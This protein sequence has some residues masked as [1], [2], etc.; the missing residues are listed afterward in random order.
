MLKSLIL[1]NK[2][3]AVELI[4]GALLASSVVYGI[5]VSKQNKKLSESLESANNNIE[6]YQDIISYK[7]N[8]NGVLKLHIQDLQN[9]K[10]SLINN[11]E[12]V[13]KTNNIKLQG[14]SSAA[15]QTQHILVKGSKGVKGDIIEILKDT[16][17]TDSIEY[18][19]LTKVYYSIGKD[20]VNINLDIKNTQYLYTYKIREYK[21]KKNFFK[22]LFTFDFKKVNRYKYQIINSNDLLKESDVR[23]IEIE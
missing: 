14:L 10:D 9:S 6:V 5:T 8:A 4:L 13:R 21:N 22:R 11:I 7:D 19:D 2:R 23:I 17:Y 12:R 16:I 3:L 20:T 15:T 18:N 1:K